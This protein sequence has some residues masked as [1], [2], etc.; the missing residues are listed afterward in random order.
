MTNGCYNADRSHKPVMVQDG[1]NA[2]GSRRMVEQKFRFTHDCQ[3][4]HSWLGQADEYC[5]GCKWRAEKP[6]L[7][8]KP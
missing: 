4:T 6:V 3:Y 7:Q 2:D 5:L 1:Y 8:S